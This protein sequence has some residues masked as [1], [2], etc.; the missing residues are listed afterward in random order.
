MSNISLYYKYI[1]K[2]KIFDQLFG[3]PIIISL[4]LLD[5]RINYNDEVATGKVSLG[6]QVQRSEIKFL[7]STFDIGALVYYSNIR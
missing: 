7:L 3:S 6:D 4:T 1:V 5:V 2:F